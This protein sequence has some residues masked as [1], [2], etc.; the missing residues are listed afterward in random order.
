MWLIKNLGNILRLVWGFSKSLSLSYSV[1][2]PGT[3]IIITMWVWCNVVTESDAEP[4]ETHVD[5]SYQQSDRENDHI[6]TW[7]SIIF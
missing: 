7:K 3:I 2:Q 4:L 5:Q 1:W 6:K